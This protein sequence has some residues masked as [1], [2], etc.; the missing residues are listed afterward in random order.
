MAKPSPIYRTDLLACPLNA[1]KLQSV[2]ALLDRV[3]TCAEQEA[4]L[5]WGLFYRGRYGPFEATATAGWTRPWCTTENPNERLPVSYAQMVMAQ[6]AGSLKGFI[7]N[8]QNTYTRLVSHCPSTQITPAQRHQ[9]HALNRAQ[10]WFNPNDF[11]VEQAVPVEPAAAHAESQA[12]AADGAP[13][14][15]AGSGVSV[16][17][18]SEPTVITQPVLVLPEIRALARSLIR[19]AL[20]LHRKPHF[21]RM[22]LA[23]DQRMASLELS[24]KKSGSFEAWV[25]LAS[26]G[27]GAR[28]A[29][30]LVLDSHLMGRQERAQ[31]ARA[32]KA[33]QPIVDENPKKNKDRKSQK[34]EAAARAPRGGAESPRKDTTKRTPRNSE[35]PHAKARRAQR[36]EDRAAFEKRLLLAPT[37]RLVLSDDRQSLKVGVVTDC[38]TLFEHDTATYQPKIQNLALDLGLC[39]FL[40]TS[41]GDLLG[42]AWMARLKRYD[43][44]LTGI[45]RHRQRLGLPV[46]SP[47]YKQYT[48]NIRGFL[49]S[50][51][52]RIFNKI[53]STQAPAHLILEALDFCNARLSKRLNRLLRNFGQGLIRQ[54]LKELEERYGITHEFR[55]AAYTSRECSSCGY[56]DSK[57][58]PSQAGFCCQFC[59]LKLHADV[60]AARVTER[61]RLVPVPYMATR[62]RIER[63][64]RERVRAFTERF[65]RPRGGPADP[66]WGNPYF[67]DWADTYRGEV[68]RDAEE[69][70]QVRGALVGC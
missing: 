34:K 69:A 1:G 19:R 4:K 39:T 14:L 50:E 21:R 67:A 10:A 24:Q 58:R 22:A 54:K 23:V 9:L 38:R 31:A 28:L 62:T 11:F 20:A 43:T 30:P 65:T 16:P 44:I 52:N 40:G 68:F 63:T 36:E 13:V 56:V 64:L 35:S 32:W 29:L 18:L 48:A 5:Q 60:N 70:S 37:I 6:V 59:G 3:R 45:A 53:V 61:Q 46:S 27:G 8:V 41:Q 57:N 49:K 15:K 42:R 51:V 55:E 12:A 7:G 25:K 26:L 17:R 33:A 47:R 66:R 2:A